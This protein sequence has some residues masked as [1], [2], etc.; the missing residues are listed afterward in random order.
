MFDCAVLPIIVL[1]CRTKL[2]EVSR[3]SSPTSA[4]S[5]LA[6]ALA[7][8]RAVAD[9]GS[10][11]GV[12]L[13]TPASVAWAT[14]GI[15]PAIDRSASVDVV[16][17]AVGRDRAVIVTTEV[18]A[19]RLAADNDLDGLGLD[20]VAVPWW[21]AQAF[22]TAAAAALGTTTEDLGSDG[23]PGFGRNISYELT[24]SRLTLDLGEQERMR[25]LGQDASAAVQ[26]ALRSWTPGEPD[27][28]VSARIAAGIERVGAFA[29]VLLVGGD[30]RL[31]R[32]RHPVAVGRPLYE[33]VMAVLVASREGLHVA[34]TRYA[35]ATEPDRELADSLTAVRRI[36]RRTLAAS[37]PGATTGDVLTEL[38]AA[39]ADE[40]HPDG[41]RQHYQGGPIGYAQREFEVAPGQ[42]DSPWWSNRLPNGCAVAWNPS[43]PGGAKD[44]DTYL[45]HEGVS[46]PIT[47]TTDWPTV[48]DELPARPAVLVVGN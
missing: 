46:E 15:N 8:V 31:R 27:R 17:L 9:R 23:H 18:E 11:S 2:L 26:G 4:R 20:L 34:L 7:R 33:V 12:V 29:P 44:E 21:D 35:A 45:V 19:P 16:W 14:G 42:I 30:D 43:L 48:D 3:L 39:Y 25:A 1:S 10:L 5:H 47:V 36:H 41:W 6:S 32:F 28:E 22:V 13:T 38:A 24:T 40:G 37:Q